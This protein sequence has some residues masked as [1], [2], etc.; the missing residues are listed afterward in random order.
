MK[1]YYLFLVAFFVILGNKQIVAQQ[2][3]VIYVTPTG[4]SSGAAGTKA[5]PASLTYAL[6]LVTAASNKIWMAQGNYSLAQ[7]IQLISNVTIEGG[8]DAAT[9]I[10]SNA[11]PTVIAKDNSNVIVA[12]NALVAFAGN[13]VSNFRLQDLT[14][15]VANAVGAQTS[16]YGIYLNGCSNYN[17]VR[18]NVTTGNAGAGVPGNG[19]TAGAAGGA[20]GAGPA[21]NGNEQYFP[22]G[23]GG[24]GGN[25]GGTGS[26]NGRHSGGTGPGSAGA[27]ACGGAGGASGTGPSCTAGCAFGSPNC[28]NATAGQPGVAGGPGTAGNVGAPGPAGTVA[29]PGFFVPGGAGGT[30]TTGT[31]G[32]GG[33][34]GGGGGGRQNSGSDDVGGGGGGGGGGG[35]GG[36]GGTGGTGGGGSFAVFL[37]NNGASGSIVDCALNPGLGGIGGAGGNGGSG[38]SGGSGGPGGAAG[39]GPNPGGAGGLGGTG[40]AGGAGGAGANGP[41]TALSENG[42]TPVTQSNIIAVP[43]NPPVIAVDN[44]GCTNAQVIFSSPTSGAWNFGT[45]ATPATGSGSGPIAVSYS[46]TGRK[47]ISFSGTSFTDFVDIYTSQS[48]SGTITGKNAPAINGC[49]DTF[50]TSISGSLYQWT[51]GANAQPQVISGASYQSA[52][53]VFL[54]PGPQWVA[55]YVTTPCCG[56]VKDSV[57]VN[58]QPNSINVSLAATKDT[59][60]AGDPITYTATPTGYLG[61]TFIVNNVPVQNSPSNTF[62]TSTLNAGDSVIVAAFD[63]VCFSNPSA[64]KHPVVNPIPTLSMAS[65]DAD[66]TICSGDNVTFTATPNGYDTYTFYD[67]AT[68]LQA[69]ATNTYSTTTLAAGNSVTVVATNK[70]CNSPQSNAIVTTVNPIPIITISTP[71]PSYCVGDNITVTANPNTYTN[72]DFSLNGASV[73]SSAA[74]TYSSTTFVTGDVVA[75]VASA[76]GC[77]SSVQTLPALTVNPIPSVSLSSSDADNSICQN[78]QITF[79][80]SPAGLALYEFF[81]GATLLQAGASETYTTTTLPAGNSVTVYATNLN[82]KSPVSNAIATAIQPAPIVD[83][84]P[85]ASAC[86]DA[87]PITLSGN[88]PLGGNWTGTGIVNVVGDF[89][90]SAAG[91]GTSTLYYSF[92]DIVTGCTGIDSLTFTVNP[93]PTILLATPAAICEGQSAQLSASGGQTYAWSPAGDLDNANSSNP[94]ATPLTTTPYTVTVTDNNSCSSSSSV[95]VTVKPNPIADFTASDVCLGLSTSFLNTSNPNVGITSAWAFGDGASSILDNPSHTYAKVDTFNVTLIVALNGCL[96]TVTHA[97]ITYPASV[98]DFKASPTLGYDAGNNPIAFTNLSKNSDTWVWDFGDIS[99]SNVKSPAHQYTTAGIYTVQLIA[100]NSY[101][102]ADTMTKNNY[103]RIYPEPKVYM[104]NAFSPNSDGKNDVLQPIV[105]GVKFFDFS[106]FN[107]W[108][109]KV[110]HSNDSQTGWDGT[111]KG[112]TVQPGTYPYLLKIVFEDGHVSDLKGSITVIR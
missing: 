71:S 7:P 75:V 93:L 35:F 56:I 108:G 112:A 66:N 14:I 111:F 43:G 59:I 12:A 105:N 53:V 58:V 51:F 106:V 32:C 5:N 97:A 45:G 101:G 55:V 48:V 84:G 34:G 103:I 99:G 10:K 98:A 82:C 23:T 52:P 11:T 16:V 37:Y 47:T 21:A 46:N 87:A 68:V 27:G 64:V 39:C 25:N 57:L 42:G 1:K 79:T 90:P 3:D 94:L 85:N 13:A 83:A 63:G 102:C 26:T 17:I 77:T 62:T 18:C 86:V 30:G 50:T 8:F 31:A 6:T 36:S 74:N 44:H 95:T 92:T 61:Y 70:G 19:G 28:G 80:A 110:Y 88:N 4:A 29:I 38:G 54:Q 78:E 91:V 41:S 96:D 89:D 20:G 72:Y 24:V 107:R 15:T 69:N 2:C 67:G 81:N 60:C 9:W 33:G 65:S 49:P 100:A 22:G 76:N 109:E 104:P 40:G 73:Q